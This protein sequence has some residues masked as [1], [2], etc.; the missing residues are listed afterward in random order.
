M[1]QIKL[2]RRELAFA[3][4][5]GALL[6]AGRTSAQGMLPRTPE[7]RGPANPTVSQTEG[8][9]FKPQSPEKKD[10]AADDRAGSPFALIGEVVTR[11]CK[12]VP[13]ALVDLWHADASGAYDNRGAR[14]RGHQFTD[15]S[16][17]F[18]FDTI[19]PGEYPGRTRHFHVK[20]TMPGRP[21]LTTQLYFPDD[22]GNARDRIYD[23]RLIMAV[24]DRGGATLGFFR[25]VL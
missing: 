10:F 16:G 14:L 4:A 20:V 19:R 2:T 11:D 6:P 9:Y 5:A 15:T 1:G 3:M 7:C 24:Q 17:R 18:R 13:R 8:P 21:V 12:P 22:P 25:F 23:P